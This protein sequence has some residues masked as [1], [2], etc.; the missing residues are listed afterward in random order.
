ML[1]SL[2]ID[3]FGI[4]YFS[5]GSFP[6]PSLCCSSAR[7]LKRRKGL[8]ASCVALI[9]LGLGCPLAWSKRQNKQIDEYDP[10]KALCRLAA[11]GT[12]GLPSWR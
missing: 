6:L 2:K 10:S 12:V 3:A 11:P 7:L 4:L 9:G 5:I 8:I 1:S